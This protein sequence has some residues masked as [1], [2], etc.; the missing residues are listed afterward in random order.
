VHGAPPDAGKDWALDY[1]LSLLTC[2]AS[3]CFKRFFIRFARLDICTP[4]VALQPP[5]YAIDGGGSLKRLPP[6]ERTLAR[7]WIPAQPG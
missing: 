1:C 5:A 7:R 3:R 4:S 2:V 6:I